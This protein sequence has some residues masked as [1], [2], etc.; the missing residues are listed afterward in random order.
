MEEA[1]YRW[2]CGTPP[3][4]LLFA[5]REGLDM[6]LEEGL[7]NAFD[8]HRRLAESV[9]LAVGVWSRANALSLNAVVPE[10]RSNSVTTIL[11][12]EGYD[13]DKLRM[14]SREKFNV[15]LG[16]GL[17]KTRGKAFRIG[18]M[19]YLNE[20]MILGALAGVEASLEASGIPHEKGGVDAAVK[21]LAA[22]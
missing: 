17:G 18:H 14:I 8:R 19:G 20:P 6:V 7:D 5:L 21:Y 12:A 22:E 16:S 3:E 1:Y 2:F 4:H 15:S 11:V 10:E 13:A 9:R